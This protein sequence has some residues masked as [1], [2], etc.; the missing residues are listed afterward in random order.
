MM[1]FFKNCKFFCAFV[2]FLPFSLVTLS[3]GQS[4][5]I[6]INPIGEVP[7]GGSFSVGGTI[8]HDVNSSAVLA[9]TP[10]KISVQINDPQGNPVLIPTP[11]IDTAGFNGRNLPF[12]FP[13]VMPWTE[14]DKWTPT[15]TWTAVVTVETPT[16]SD[17]QNE[18]FT[19][20]IAN[21]TI[22][23]DQ[24]IVA[25]PGDLFDLSGIISNLADVQTEPGV[26]FK[27]MAQIDGSPYVHET[28]FPNPDIAWSLD[29]PW[30][31]SS[32]STNPFTIPNLYV[33]LDLV[34]DGNVTL[35]VWVDDGP[36]LSDI[37]I[38]HEQEEINDNFFNHL[39]SI[40]EGVATIIPL[41]NS[42]IINDGQEGIFQGGDSVR[43]QLTIKNTGNGPLVPGTPIILRVALS[44]DM[45]LSQDDFYLRE[46][47]L[48]LNQSTAT[49][50]PNETSTLDWIQ[51]LPDN[52]KGDYYVVAD[53]NEFIVS[54]KPT[55]II[56][57]RSENYLNME[58]HS[59]P[60]DHQ[61]L[62]SR[63]S[64]SSDG[65]V[66]AFEQMS[67][68]LS[69]ILLL[70]GDGRA[71]L[72]ISRGIGRVLP[73]AS[74]YAPK[75]SAD[76]RFVVFHSHA[77]NLVPGD[78]NDHVDVFRYEIYNTSPVDAN[79]TGRLTRLSVT[80]QGRDANGGS[81]Y[82]VISGDGSRVAFESHASNLD[83]NVTTSGK[84][85]YLWSESIAQE[86]VSNEKLSGGN[87][88]VIASGNADS[89][90]PD[91]SGDG[92]RVVFTTF[93]N[94][95]V[96]GEIDN[97]KNSDIVLWENGNYFYAG[98]THDG[99]LPMTGE[100]KQPA[101][102]GDGKVITF[103]SSARN[104][105]SGKGISHILIEDAGAG[106]SSGSM[107]QVTDANGS[108]AV[109]SIPDDLLNPYGE[110]LG[111][112][113]DV[114]GG[115]YVQ[116]SLSVIPPAGQPEPTR[117]LSATPL[118]VNPFGDVFRIT[119]D[120][121]KAKSGSIRVSES[122]PLSSDFGSKTGGNTGSRE[123][124]ISGDGS[125]IAYSTTA[126][127][128][129]DLN[130]TSTNLKTHLNKPFSP[131]SAQAFL[132]HGIGSIVITDGGSGYSPGVV[133]ISSSTG[134]G[135]G[136]QATAQVLNGSIVSVTIQN[137]GSGY[138][139]SQTSIIPPG[140]GTGFTYVILP[141]PVN[142]S[143]ATRA[144][145]G[146]IHRVEITNPG[147]GY[148]SKGD[149]LQQ[150]TEIL[151]DGDGADRD[152]DGKPDARF[153]PD[154]LHIGLNGEVYIEQKIKISLKNRSALIGGS[155]TISDPFNDPFTLSF[156]RS[157]RQPFV[158]GV[159]TNNTFGS[160]QTD[161]GLISDINNSLDSYY[162]GQDLLQGP[163]WE[164]NGTNLTIS[165]LNGSVS[166]NRSTA[167]QVQY[168]SN[169]IIGGNGYSQ[170]RAIPFV[171]P[172]PIIFGFSEIHTTSRTVNTSNGRPIYGEYNLMIIERN[173][174]ANPDPLHGPFTEEEIDSMVVLNDVPRIKQDNDAYFED[175]N[176]KNFTNLY[177]LYPPR[178][179]VLNEYDSVDDMSDDIYLYD[180]NLSN[181]RRLSVNKFG[182][183]TNYLESTPLPSH[184]HPF[185]SGNGRQV[186]FSSD[187][188]GRGGIIFGESNQDYLDLN[189]TRSIY[190]HDLKSLPYEER[191][192]ARVS[193]SGSTFSG[194]DSIIYLNTPHPVLVH[195]STDMTSSA[196][197]N[198]SG[199]RWS[200]AQSRRSG[201]TNSSA[202]GFIS[203][204]RLYADN[205]MVGQ[206]TLT[207]PGITDHNDSF[208]WT[209]TRSGLHSLTASM[210]NNIGEEFYSEPIQINVKYLDTA[211][212]VK[213][214][215]NL[216]SSLGNQITLNQEF[217]LFV[218][219]GLQQGHA[220]EVRLYVDGQQVS[221][222]M[223]TVS[224]LRDYRSLLSWTPRSQ[225]NHYVMASV[226]DNT[227][228]ETFGNGTLFRVKAQNVN[229]IF[230][231]IEIYPGGGIANQT[232]QG[233]S[234]VSSVQFIGA[235][236]KKAHI[237]NASFFLNDTLISTQTDPPFNVSFTPPAFDGNTT[238]S[239]WSLT[240]VAEDLNG[241]KFSTS[242]TGQ[243][244][245]TTVL[246]M[247][248]LHPITTS[249][250]LSENE[251]YD[252][253]RITLQATI[254]GD[255]DDLAMVQNL[256]FFGNG[257]VLD[258]N[259]TGVPITSSGGQI[260]SI[261]YE[262]DWDIEFSRYA[263][264]D[265]TVEI[266][267][268]SQLAPIG[269][270]NPV[271]ISSPLVITISPPTPWV[272]E[273]SGA[274]SIFSDLTDSNMST[275][276]AEALLNRI[277]SAEENA[278]EAWVDELGEVASFQQKLN[279]VA[280]YHIC[281]GEW[282]E[283][284]LDLETAFNQWIPT[285]AVNTNWLKNYI[286]FVLNSNQYIAKHG[287]VSLLVGY[288]NEK[289]IHDFDLN[290]RTF[291]E[292]CLTNKYGISPT[293]QQMF[294][295][296]K[297]MVH[298]WD[299]LSGG[300]YWEVRNGVGQGGVGVFFSPPRLDSLTTNQY[301]SGEC[302]VDFVMKLTEE[303]PIGGL[304]YILYTEPLRNSTYKVATFIQLL[305][306]ENA[307]PVQDS[308]IKRLSTMPA[309]ES[310]KLILNDY[311]YTSRF[312]LI[313]KDSTVIDPSTPSWKNE[314][315]FGY[316][317][318]KHFPW[319]Y[320]TKYEWIYIA[321][322]SPTQFWFHYP[323]LGWLWTGAGYYKGGHVYS[324]TLQEWIYLSPENKTYYSQVSKSWVSYS[325]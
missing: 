210:V 145:G 142:G 232:T 35:T 67:D 249:A 53:I 195:A 84:N 58:M 158:I 163:I 44:N 162:N 138:P 166:T 22:S 99:Q 146:T 81:F 75:V 190:S 173:T 304:P 202:N 78:D 266:I 37:S 105:V 57:M 188:S 115:N 224:G 100:T 212:Q 289:D 63:P 320:H 325:D 8:S 56:T 279:I 216:T 155:L 231:T 40:D 20:L 305:W 187:A 55:P 296:S 137:Q 316:F 17:N 292:L 318:D 277:N 126:S 88:Q 205:F 136:A 313:W 130:R 116:P 303:V 87:I 271:I 237:A 43:C 80:A 3:H 201:N 120:G 175:E 41:E 156:D 1:D 60:P 36:R 310:I 295:G 226:I 281:L 269:G 227:G 317:W 27:V 276:Q 134:F 157:P 151:I 132:H 160:L 69:R 314:D 165:V 66:M 222:E 148:P 234:L 113:I 143:G 171:S 298:Y 215:T 262:I 46:V 83:E 125:L 159:D 261:E 25:R 248:I 131:A 59:S 10:V 45:L 272:D 117:I 29:Q 260:Q 135:T 176:P 82:P 108:G 26:F 122:Q 54:P 167:L 185:I 203:Q 184:R 121:V 307:D 91:I 97:N 31:I 274:F 211:S 178:T 221:S 34:T 247:L 321:G 242:T 220:Q 109:I 244:S 107:V 284:Y 24:F 47:D 90:D 2:L 139:L 102:S 16:S 15:A 170:N 147:R 144:G 149:S 94:D 243:I 128:L 129:L 290:R 259:I 7:V 13:L 218:N 283:S 164:V 251:V 263:K 204:M 233:S 267:A 236:G 101:I 301:Q 140:G 51:M 311:R 103:V 278:L 193:I 293:F 265:G 223:I 111:F 154:R 150:R 191:T 306:R 177:N 179:R 11:V 23:T 28:T 30:P 86:I 183:P 14:D 200:N 264:P 206:K 65:R 250:G 257:I 322:V 256:D 217:S 186:F 246:P 174:A 96:D 33:P 302:A 70:H 79:S 300:N 282:H 323:D 286:D 5:S 50:G 229:S 239:S 280:S 235:N 273:K 309:K 268:L 253:Q 254:K 19:L 209:P 252:K 172:R 77:S 18:A 213:L 71:P 285:G 98:R 207:V 64:T 153:N 240:V 287:I 315:W 133:S 127:N 197:L 238:L 169:M 62:H 73:N 161:L 85:I 297:R 93:A 118:L 225:G 199:R 92:T 6:A 110:I 255:S 74:S 72:D 123:P 228:K 189:E 89:F 294:Q 141:P 38:I 49:L 208:M 291:A 152:G 214:A 104:M 12:A 32:Q 61:E 124:T 194:P 39:L 4:F 230:G 275:A 21:L 181:N 299:N 319:V 241:T 119:V 245:Q 114:P 106:Y 192:D 42:F 180:H 76:G 198:S 112:S 219:I 196:D 68:G 258:G 48:S 324:N 168:L 9:G 52:F 312:N 308:D 288:E 270:N 95:L 182:F